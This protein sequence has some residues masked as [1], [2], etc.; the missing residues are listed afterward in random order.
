MPSN[1][2]PEVTITSGQ[3]LVLDAGTAEIGTVAEKLRT[4]WYATDSDASGTTSLAVK[5]AGGAGIKHYVCGIAA[6]TDTGTNGTAE[7]GVVCLITGTGGGSVYIMRFTIPSTGIYTAGY[8]H[9]GGPAIITFASPL[10]IAANTQI[11]LEVN[12]SGSNTT[13]YANMWGFTV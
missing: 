5:A 10:E 9:G 4:T 3:S 2:Y 11:S 7:T 13:S 8:A 12:P 1:I 6:S